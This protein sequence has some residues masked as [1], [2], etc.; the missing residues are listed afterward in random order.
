MA[1]CNLNG[2]KATESGT[3]EPVFRPIVDS[4]AFEEVVDQL[5]HAVHTG[6]YEVG[7]R[8]PTID[9]LARAMAVS[10]PTVGEAVRMLT[11]A[12]VLNVKRGASG[13]IVVAASII[14]PSVIKLSSRHLAADMR[15]L[16][17]AR[18]PVEMELARLAALRADDSDIAAM[19][20]GRELN[21]TA[22][23]DFSQ[24]LFGN[25]KFHYAIGR[26]ARSNLLFHMLAD[27]YK[28]LAM[29]VDGWTPRDRMDPQA[30]I[31]E[32]LEILTAIEQHDPDLARS[33][34]DKHLLELEELAL[35]V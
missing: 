25:Y 24:W 26:A 17:E 3:L 35:G 2:G 8:L 5:S 7:A 12:G 10:R 29:L 20:A 32:H 4:R 6:V 30:T 31:A 28:E 9:E 16:V 11:R 18:R 34:M 23:G 21:E 14:P 22:D 33:A 27:I 19:R 1:R 15:E 13:G